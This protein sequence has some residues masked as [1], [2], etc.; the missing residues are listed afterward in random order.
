MP[1]FKTTRTYAQ[2]KH[3][4]HTIF[5]DPLIASIIL[6]SLDLKDIGGL[7]LTF[8][9]DVF[10]HTVQHTVASTPRLFYDAETATAKRPIKM[11]LCD[12]AT[13]AEHRRDYLLSGRPESAYIRRRM[14]KELVAMMEYYVSDP[15]IMETIWRADADV[16]RGIFGRYL[17]DLLDLIPQ[18]SILRDTIIDVF[19]TI[20][21]PVVQIEM[22]FLWLTLDVEEYGIYLL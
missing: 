3:L 20:Y 21:V 7:L 19:R 2:K 4:V 17:L 14:S 1:R 8:K 13:H 5:G 16:L 9:V 15:D 6:Q 18:D 11:F 10:Y 12:V 22:P